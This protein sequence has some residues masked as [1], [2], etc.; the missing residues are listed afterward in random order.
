MKK[1]ATP[2]VKS[3][4]AVREAGDGVAAVERA[5]SIV[6]ALESADQTMTLAELAV[7]TGYYKSTILRLLGSLIA[8]GYVTRL[9][10][11]AYDLGP[12]AFRL[13]VAF[14][15][16]NA[17]GHHVV[18]ALQELVDRGTESA[19]FHVRQDADHRVCLFRVNSRHAT[20]DRVE[21]GQSYALL[22]G[23]AG[24][25]ILAYEGAAGPRY[26]AI[27][28]SGSDVS[29]GERD[30]SCA[31][32]AAPVFGPRSMLVGVISLS[33]PRERF[34]EAEIAEMKRLLGP[35]AETL[36]RNLGGDWP[37]SQR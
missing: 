34:G 19:S 7:R 37:V 35:V 8:T 15:R 25:I 20:L 36:T 10:D 22:R 29:L 11:G 14:T 13:G 6:A 21:A 28:A 27:R 12:T 18:P 2:Q 17:L 16:K 4:P 31:A 33:G 24:H 26:D 1:L 5:L 30:P 3:P 9:P 32:V 23:A